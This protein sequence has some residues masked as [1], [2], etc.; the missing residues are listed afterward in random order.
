MHSTD[1][2]QGGRAGVR[3]ALS[4]V[5]TVTAKRITM[6]RSDIANCLRH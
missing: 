1:S 2:G 5:S 3:R 4:T 6:T